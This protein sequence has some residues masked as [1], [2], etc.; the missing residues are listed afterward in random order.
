[1]LL[2][3]CEAGAEPWLLEI[4]HQPIDHLTRSAIFL[5]RLFLVLGLGIQASQSEV[6]LPELRRVAN[7][8]GECH[9]LPQPA[10]GFVSLM[11]GKGNFSL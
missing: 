9:C 7:R 4:L 11:A 5:P 3:T 8:L 10:L 6:G 1:M 2:Q